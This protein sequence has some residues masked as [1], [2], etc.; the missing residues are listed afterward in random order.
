MGAACVHYSR[1]KFQFYCHCIRGAGALPDARE[2]VYAA[3]ALGPTAVK[4]C[5]VC[6]ARRLAHAPSSSSCH[7]SESLLVCARRLHCIALWDVFPVHNTLSTH[8]F[9]AFFDHYAA[10]YAGWNQFD[11]DFYVSAPKTSSIDGS[12]HRMTVFDNRLVPGDTVDFPAVS[13]LTKQQ[14]KRQP[15]CMLNIIN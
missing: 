14:L 5:I 13:L 9:P 1:A 7:S 6:V 12:H 8:P 4:L 11:L 10:M 2:V 15:L 3:Y